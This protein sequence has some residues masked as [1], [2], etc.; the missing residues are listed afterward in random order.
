MLKQGVRPEDVTMLDQ[1]PQQLSK[2]RAKPELQSLAA[3]I[4]GDAENLPAN[5]T[6]RFDRYTSAGSIEYECP[7]RLC[8][9]RLLFRFFSLRLRFESL[10]LCGHR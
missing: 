1:S 9:Q 5:W 3:I 8:N 6:G 2:A 7:P 4:E 10:G